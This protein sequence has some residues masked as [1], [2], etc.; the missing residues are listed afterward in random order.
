MRIYAICVV[1]NEADI[2]EYTLR[3]AT[4]WADKVLVYDNGSTDGTWDKV[5]SIDDARII[6]FKQDKRPYSDGLRAQVFNAFKSELS[7]NDWWVI[8]DGDEVY[9]D[10]PR[11]FLNKNK[12]SYH[13]VNGKKVDV[14][15]N[16]N[17]IKELKFSGDFSRDIKLF[18]HFTPEAW[19][20]PR[21]IKHRVGMRW[22]E[23]KIWPTHM[24]LVCR[25]PIKI[26]HYPLRSYEQIKRR[27]ETR[28]NMSESGGQLFKHWEKDTWS[29]YYEQKSLSIQKFNDLET[30]FSEVKMAND[31]N[32]PFIKRLIKSILHNS[33][34]IK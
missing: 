30:V 25:S 21:M 19:S 10:N 18:D 17:E 11:E 32:Q 27:W 4:D 28:H 23:K 7:G 1:K 20:E 6:P 8:Q 24:G 12:G 33:G 15:F 14:C 9:F 31:F 3:K 22:L 16:L 34:L 26:I 5:L 2:I 13:H 29:S